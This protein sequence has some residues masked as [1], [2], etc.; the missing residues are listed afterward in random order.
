MLWVLNVCTTGH[1]TW[2][3]VCILSYTSQYL[4]ELSS[5][6]YIPKLN[7]IVKDDDDD[8]KVLDYGSKLFPFLL[9]AGKGKLFLFNMTLCMF[10]KL[11]KTL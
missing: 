9:V 6:S 2:Q 5:L 4:Y 7:W 1:N 8:K 10:T 3:A 11:A